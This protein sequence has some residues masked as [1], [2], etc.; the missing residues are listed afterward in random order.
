MM[1]AVM[2]G[3][4]RRGSV[5]C[6][7]VF[8][9][10]CAASAAAQEARWYVQTRGPRARTVEYGT[11]RTDGDMDI[12][13]GDSR[14][15][16]GDAIHWRAGVGTVSWRRIDEQAGTDFRAEREGNVIR[17]SGSL[18][19]RKVSR[20][21]RIDAAPW[22]QIF[23]PAILDLLP[24]GT[25]EREFWTVDPEKLSAHKMLV[26]RVGVERITV[27]G[28]IADAFKIH[29]SPAGALAPFWGADFWYRQSDWTYLASRLPELGGVTVTEIEEPDR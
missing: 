25:R 11:A 5:F 26:K 17:V 14:Q 19:N 21:N 15:G 2:D 8:L 28:F 29:F 3:K 10:L 27:R 7:C 20:E 4:K 24:T 18:R 22:Y 1:I 6:A 16:E 12:H 9:L 13:S 23:G